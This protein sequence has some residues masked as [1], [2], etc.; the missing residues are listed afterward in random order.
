M[1]LK[2]KAPS[3]ATP[4]GAPRRRRK[5]ERPGE[6][7]AAALQVFAEKGFAAARLDD[8]AKAAGVSKGTIYL[9]YPSKEALFEAVVLNA[10][11]PLLEQAS[12][13]AIDTERSCE[14]VLGF[15]IGAMY[16]QIVAT[17]RREI[18]RL[19]IAESSRF[20][21]LVEF[22]HREAISRGKSIMSVILQRGVASGEFR[23]CLAIRHPEIVM[24]PVVLAVIW[25]LVFD[26]IEPLDLEHHV[27]A[28]LDL[29]LGG[30]RAHPA[31]ADRQ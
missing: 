8:V 2:K 6:I 7:A 25:K 5:D 21:H 18:M 26:P 16:R 24:G 4:A 29:I 9:Y 11:G 23:D 12:H 28:H 19:V 31:R 3:S 1:N 30:L 17:K 14:E 20:P 22:Y 15:V 13:A 27:Q 10:F